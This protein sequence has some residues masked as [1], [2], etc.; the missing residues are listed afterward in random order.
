MID[1]VEK[2]YT[3]LQIGHKFAIT[4]YS[5]VAVALCCYSQN[6]YFVYSC[7]VLLERKHN[8]YGSAKEIL[9]HIFVYAYKI[10]SMIREHHTHKLQTTPWHREEEPH[11]N[12]ETPGRQTKQSNQPSLPYQDDCKTRMDL[13]QRTTKHRT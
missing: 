12:H 6:V 1:V 10:E 4:L 8:L 3:L 9:E 13:K 5:H 7:H 11:N 2:K